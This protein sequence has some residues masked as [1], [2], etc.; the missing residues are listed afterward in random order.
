MQ[1][2]NKVTVSQSKHIIGCVEEEEEEE[3]CLAKIPRQSRG[4]E[5]ART[6]SNLGE[7]WPRDL[8]NM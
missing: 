2:Q 4:E 8:A 7:R 1:G 5:V 3:E 6:R